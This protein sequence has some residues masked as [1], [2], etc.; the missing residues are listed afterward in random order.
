MRIE[1][2][3]FELPESLIAQVP[4]DDRSSSRMLHVERQTG[5]IH[6]RMFRDL[7]S[8]LEAGDVLVMNNTRVTARRLL[9]AKHGTGGAVEALLLTP[10]AEPN[11]F[12]ALTK[13][14]KRLQVGAKI[15]FQDDLHAEVVGVLEGGL[16]ALRFAPVPDFNE[17]IARAGEIP[18]PPYITSRASTE[19][20]YQTVYSKVP[21]SAA[22]PTA[23]LHFTSEILQALAEKGVQI[24]EVTLDVG[25]DTFRP[26][27]TEN[28]TEH[29]MHGETC[30]VSPATA[31]VVNE[32]K[33][34]LITVGTTSTRTIE[35][36]A[37]PGGQVSPG[38]TSTSIFFYPG[39]EF[40]AVDGMLTNFHM[41]RTTMLLMVSAMIGYDAWRESYKLAIEEK[42]RFLS[43]GDSML[44]L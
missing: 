29:P 9:G 8:L 4:L 32:R 44:L 26:I 2:F 39:K 22:A 36:V 6:H 17:K 16:R 19:A 15:D 11:T 40:Q 38:R 20:Q 10:L 7:V 23:G 14:A 41:P 37:Q 21:G 3:D 35:T 5:S 27:L 28:V 33:G 12:V 43:F 1:D 24:A 13:P 25:I 42:Y 30:E 18:L 31:Q 34:R